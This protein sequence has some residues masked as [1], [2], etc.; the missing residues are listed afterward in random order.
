M[1]V[2]Q[3]HLCAMIIFALWRNR[4]KA[5]KNRLKS[6]YWF[7]FFKVKAHFY[8]LCSASD[9]FSSW[10]E[11][12]PNQTTSN[13]LGWEAFPVS[14]FFFSSVFQFFFIKINV[15]CL[16]DMFLDIRQ[17]GTYLRSFLWPAKWSVWLPAVIEK[18]ERRRSW[19]WKEVK[20]KGRRGQ[21]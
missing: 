12:A 15:F 13:I 8:L 3:W 18:E 2:Y 16:F 1:T 17:R 11:D 5:F 21:K 19:W 7:F 6:L 10:L 9:L 14:C 20:K 4:S